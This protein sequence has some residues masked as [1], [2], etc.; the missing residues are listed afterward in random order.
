MQRIWDMTSPCSQ[1]AP[2]QRRQTCSISTGEVAVGQPRSLLLVVGPSV[3]C[4]QHPQMI[5]IC[6]AKKSFG[7]M[8]QA[9]IVP[10]VIPPRC[11]P[12]SR[13]LIF[14]LPLLTRLA[15]VETSIKVHF[16]FQ[17]TR[18]Q[19]VSKVCLDRGSRNAYSHVIGY[20]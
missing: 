1:T 17:T 10:A 16:H 7:R 12:T 20:S 9:K 15:L 2:L 18:G 19:T 4:L 13:N 14:F 3:H 8:R 5:E 6:T 11:M